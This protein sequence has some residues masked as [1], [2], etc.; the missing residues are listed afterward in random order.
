MKH[1]RLWRSPVAALFVIALV[2]APLVSIAA[3][4]DYPKA[5]TVDQV[6]DFFGTKVADPY[7]WLEN[8]DDPEVQAWGDAENAVTQSYIGKIPFR[9]QVAKRLTELL[10][11]PRVGLPTKRGPWVFFSK[12]SGLQNQAVIYKQMG[13]NGEP[14]PLLD[15]NTMSKDGTVSISALSY[16]GDGKMVG[17]GVSQSGSDWEVLHVRDV[18]TGKDRADQIERCRFTAIAW[19]PDNSGF[20]YSRYP[21]AGSVPKG[22]E[23]F[24]Q[25]L[26]F[27]RLGEAQKKDR[28]VY[29]RPDC[30]ECGT[31]PGVSD[32]GRWLVIHVWKGTAT[33]NEIFVQRLGQPGAQI[34]PVFTGFDASWSFVESSGEKLYFESDKDAPRHRVV[35]VDMAGDRQPSTVVPEGTDVIGNVLIANGQLVISRMHNAQSRLFA[36]GLDG[37]MLHEVK[38]PTIGTI[39]GLSG[40]PNDPDLYVSFTS[41]LFPPQSYRY[42]F[43][44]GALDLYKDASVDFDRTAFVARQVFFESKDGTKIPMFL[45]HKKGL[46]LDG[47]NPTLL[48]GYGGFN[49]SMTPAFS[50]SRL[51]WLE[52]GGVYAVANLR[53]GGEFGEEWHKAGTLDRK[54]NVFDDF[55]GAAEWLIDNDYT[56]PEK[57]AIQ[58]GSNG[59]LL[60]AACTLQRPDLY[61]CVLSQVP[62]IDM[63]R[64]Q[65]FTIGAYW[66]PDYGDPENAAAFKALIQYSPAHNVK[67]GTKFP[68]ML[69]TTADT[70]TR[71]HPMHAK[72]FAAAVQAANAG[73]NPVL[74]RVETKAGHGAG[75]PTSKQI[76]ESA[77]LYSCV[78]D[79]LG[80]SYVA[81]ERAAKRGSE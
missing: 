60:T 38:L 31:S 37:Q 8:V 79:R 58:G 44:S 26:Y 69:I 68:S 46:M 28:L 78:M 50:T 12:N 19:A 24:W 55:I 52:Q 6:D 77:D 65:K 3:K 36:F 73:D 51:F 27:H 53:G 18:A 66:K 5:K 17:Y 10:D 80:M 41:F 22:D 71:V 49:I 2:A 34:E 61:G 25:K 45:V 29:E 75:K 32:D 21:D 7:R 35:T 47:N 43:K 9:A 16:T 33:E 30:K 64:Y 56:R 15:P 13:A 81:S 1:A 70:D 20:Y 14:Q 40:R 42:D 54:Q 4:L 11:Y 72:K 59:G 23:E 48:Y 39:A 62:V 57:L 74:L 63:L 76:E 67:P